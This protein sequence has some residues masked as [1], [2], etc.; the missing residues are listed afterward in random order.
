[1]VTPCRLIPAFLRKD[2]SASSFSSHCHM[3]LSLQQVTRGE[4][5]QSLLTKMEMRFCFSYWAQACSSYARLLFPHMVQSPTGV[6]KALLS[7][8]ASSIKQ[9]YNLVRIGLG[10]NGKALWAGTGSVRGGV[11][12]VFISLALQFLN[13][14]YLLWSLSAG[15]NAECFPQYT[16]PALPLTSVWNLE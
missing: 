6:W 8:S 9:T 3:L 14:A 2:K 1:M 5:H 4:S 7:V 16:H 10:R 13:G 12:I 15:I 11:L